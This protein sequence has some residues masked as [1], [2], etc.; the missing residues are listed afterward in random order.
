MG[1]MMGLSYVYVM[2][3][4]DVHPYFLPVSLPPPLTHFFTTS[5]LHLPCMCMY[6]HVPVNACVCASVC[7]HRCMHACMYVCVHVHMFP[8]PATTNCLWVLRRGGSGMGL[9]NHSLALTV[10]L[11]FY[12]VL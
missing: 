7:V 2:Y 6:V 8:F 4:D 10:F 11:L 12:G 5:S 9:M 1:F 3:F